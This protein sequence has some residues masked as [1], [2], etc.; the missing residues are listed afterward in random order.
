MPGG[1]TRASL[2]NDG[3]RSNLPVLGEA[4][5]FTG[6]PALVQH[7]TAA[8][9]T[10]G[11]LRGR[12]VLIDFWTYTCINC[13]RT[14]PYVRA[15]DER[16]AR[17]GLTIVGVHTP[18]FDFEKDAGNVE[19]AIRQNRLGYAVAQDNEYGTWNAWGNK[20]W[21]AKYLI[22]SR[23]R[24]RY[25]HFGEGVI[26]R[27]PRLRSAPCSQEAGAGRLGSDVTARAQ[28]TVGAE[29]RRPRPISAR[30]APSG[31]SR[32]RRPRER[33]A[34]RPRASGCRRTASP[35]RARGT[36]ARESARA[37]R[38]ASLRRPLRRAPRVPRD[39][40][41]GR[42][43]AP[44]AGAAG[45]PPGRGRA[46][47]RRPGGVVPCAASVSTGSSR[48][49][50]SSAGSSSCGSSPACPPTRS[51]SG[52]QGTNT[53]CTAKTPL[54]SV[55][56][57]PSDPPSATVTWPSCHTARLPSAAMPGVIA[58]ALVESEHTDPVAVVARH[59]ARHH[60][61]ERGGRR[62]SRSHPAPRRS[63]GL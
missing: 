28:T 13:I 39:V 12:V 47:G 15:W 14:L 48:C 50:G 31:F 59:G 25:A 22:D 40:V 57:I 27:R 38:G 49:H 46:A 51:R 3:P 37:V 61:L 9:L 23:G 44:R 4:P 62:A 16:Y 8:P 6:Q 55:E 19:R 7:R 17:R 1:A 42:H 56:P 26:R 43:A 63:G 45:R 33:I 52:D 11:G 10:L 29:S 24:V 20:Y 54:G 32:T 2:R 35:W 18:E 36:S 34:T 21:P 58:S 53:P 30:S 60:E 5:E 41:G